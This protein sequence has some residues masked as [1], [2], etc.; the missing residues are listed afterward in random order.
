[1]AYLGRWEIDD[2]VTFAANTHTPATGAATDADAVPDYRVYENETT[3]P[4]LTGSMALLDGSNTI[5]F[6]SEAITLSAANGFEN[7]KCYTIYVSATVGGIT[8]TISH[9]FQVEAALATQTSVDTVD[10]FLDTEITDIRNRL[11]AALVSGRIDASVGAMAADV[12]TAAAI[13]TDAL[14]ALEL[15]AGAANEIADAVLSRG[16]SNVQDTADTTS[17]AAII[18][19]IFESSVSGTVWTIRKTGGTTFVT[20]TLTTDPAAA[21]VV[22]VT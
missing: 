15:S 9:T 10:D 22:G 16:V 17:L 11:P 13:A 4:I 1:M 19:A 5:G 20:K 21:P 3:T 12:V 8:G 14:G 7:G 18:L 6:Y 2:V